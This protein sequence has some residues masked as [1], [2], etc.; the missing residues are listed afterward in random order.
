MRALVTILLAF[1]SLSACAATVPATCDEQIITGAREL[2]CDQV[3][4]AARGQ[5][6]T[7]P[8][9]TA[10]VVQWGPLCPPNARC[11]A[12]GADIATVFANIEGGS[13][14]YVTVRLG[15]DGSVQVDTPQPVPSEFEP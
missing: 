12:A 10:L 7:T 15:P 1:W 9:I 14:L 8:G 13:Q 3:V 2:S 4:A 11:A 5:F 6:A